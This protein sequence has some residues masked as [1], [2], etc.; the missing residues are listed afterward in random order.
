MA[1]PVLWIDDTGGNVGYVDVVT[2]VAT[3][4]GYAGLQ[5][6]DLA[7]SPTEQ[8]YGSTFSALYL[9]NQLNGAATLVGNFGSGVSINGL[10]FSPDGTLYGSGGA[11]LYTINTSTGAAA[12]VGNSGLPSG[13]V[14][15]GDLA[16]LNG[17]LYESVTDGSVSDLALINPT[18]GAGQLVGTIVADPNVLG[19]ATGSNGTLYGVDGTNLYTISPTTGSGTLVGSYSNPNLEDAAGAA[20]QI[21]A[22]TTPPVTN[23]AVFDTTTGQ[24]I[25]ATA[26]P[27]TGPVGGLQEQYINVTPDNLNI[28]VSTP[29][30]FL[31]SGSGT[32]AIAV[33]SG[34]N[35]LDGGTGSNFLTGGSG[36]DTFFVDD[37]GPTVDIWSTVNGFHAGDAATIWGV[38]PQD[39]D[40]SWVD[41]QGATGF[42]GLTLHATASGQPT[43]SLTLAGYTSADLSDGRLSVS[44]GTDPASGSAYM[45]VRGNS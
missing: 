37:R 21:E 25:S 7:F 4:V 24:P 26:Q 28:S 35:V 6:T 10:V 5:L 44:F 13:F 17:N 32:D 18:S 15:A 1:D 19:L 20:S 27:Y 29:N 14:S 34:T 31:H 23:L 8:L 33:N 3:P 45:Y 16:F 42:T 41:G 12:L 2:G 22:V 36:S 43:A 30:W 38:T 40:L 9:V 39:F 11:G